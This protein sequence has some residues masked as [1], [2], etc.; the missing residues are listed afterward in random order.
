[1]DRFSAWFSR[2]S[3]S[4][5]AALGLASESA[6]DEIDRYF[7]ALRVGA[8]L[9]AWVWLWL[10]AA[11]QAAAQGIGLAAVFAVYSLALY[12]HVWR[13]PRTRAGAYLTLLPADLI[14]LFLT[15]LWSAQPMSGV[16]LGFYLI[17]ALNAFY[18]GGV[19]GM[20]AAIGFAAL[21]ASLYFSVQ[22]PL[23]CAPE[24]LLLRLG[25]G[26]FIA[27]SM[28]LISHQLRLNR[29]HLS[30]LNRE[31]QH[32]NRTLEQTYRHLSLGRLAAGVAHHINNPAAIILSRADLMRRRGE[33]EGIPRVYLDDMTTIIE[34]AF[35]IGR[36]TRSLVALS[37]QREVSMQAL[38]LAKVIESVVVLFEN[39][40]I[41]RR[42]RITH[43]LT[44][45]LPVRGKESA[46]R[47]VVV[48]LLCNA[49]D[50]VEDGGSVLVETCQGSEPGTVELRISDDGHG[51]S[52]EHLDDIFNPFF[53]TKNGADGVGLGLC[54][55]LT[56]V[57]RLGGTI[58]ANS[59]PGGGATF[60]VTL[61]L[62]LDPEGV[63][64]P[65]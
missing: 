58:A 62:V 21:Y 38:D 9:A 23:R 60:T 37:P 54:Q 46:L 47:Q 20:V 52:Q 41:E 12:L 17:V 24:E 28:A 55:S 22:P 51:I 29:R 40:A 64:Q 26:F 5:P 6:F 57:R 48:N 53:T 14:F 59:S 31:L 63:Q 8:A 34:H 61:P 15:C 35:R 1:M 56:I 2:L 7:F 16:Y 45:R 44:P 39:G 13:Y 30:A 65:I 32:R 27:V 19:I 11:P 43:H 4:A 49:L 10:L 42:V 33:R 3:P 18:F 25:F 36:V 50:A